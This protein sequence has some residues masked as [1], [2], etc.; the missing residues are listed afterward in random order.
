MS[1][2]A[3]TSKEL[4]E[5]SFRIKML[6]AQLSGIRPIT[7]MICDYGDSGSDVGDAVESI[8]ALTD[9]INSSLCEV[10]GSLGKIA[11]EGGA[12]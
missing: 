9:Y 2:Q 8:G 4:E 10:A 5:I 3:N 1:A 11:K 7:R 6:A 12:T